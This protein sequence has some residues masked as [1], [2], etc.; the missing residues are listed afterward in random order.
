M[1]I[2]RKDAKLIGKGC[3]LDY[4]IRIG[5]KKKK[6]NKNSPRLWRV[7]MEYGFILRID[8]DKFL[9]C[10]IHNYSGSVLFFGELGVISWLLFYFR[11]NILKELVTL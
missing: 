1:S 9:F 11:G 6:R 7:N 2:R 10:I 3:G 5:N 8:S 4:R